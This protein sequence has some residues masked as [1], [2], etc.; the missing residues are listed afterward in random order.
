SVHHH[1]VHEGGWTI[2]RGVEGELVFSSPAAAGCRASRRGSRLESIITWL[3][4]W[5]DA[6]DVHPGPDT[7]MPRWDGHAPTTAAVEAL[8]AVDLLRVHTG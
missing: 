4:E 5:T 3:G 6:H 1:L 2:A 7:N 8:L